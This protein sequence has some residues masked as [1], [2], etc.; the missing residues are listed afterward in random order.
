MS[1]F[2]P[3]LARVTITTKNFRE[4]YSTTLSLHLKA[5]GSYDPSAFK[6]AALY[7]YT[8]RRLQDCSL[9]AT[10]RRSVCFRT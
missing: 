5:S 9:H 10:S 3:I 6:T 4:R 8:V 1:Y 2:I 7:C